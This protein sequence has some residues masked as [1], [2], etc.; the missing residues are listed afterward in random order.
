MLCF[1][2]CLNVCF[3]SYIHF[4]FHT[5]EFFFFH[6]FCQKLCR[7]TSFPRQLAPPHL[8]LIMENY[9]WAASVCVWRGLEAVGRTKREESEG[10]GGWCQAWQ[11]AGSVWAGLAA[12]W[13]ENNRLRENKVKEGCGITGKGQDKGIPSKFQILQPSLPPSIFFLF[14]TLEWVSLLLRIKGFCS[15]ANFR[16]RFSSSGRSCVGQP[17]LGLIL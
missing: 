9:L 11:C 12:Y 13:L 3:F 2:F 4:S 16:Y 1:F 5:C 15:G 8:S 14:S 7:T 6:L 17:Q 10:G